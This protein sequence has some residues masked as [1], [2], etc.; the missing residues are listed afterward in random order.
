MLLHDEGGRRDVGEK[1]ALGKAELKDVAYVLPVVQY[2]S[3]IKIHVFPS[4][5]LA[6]FC[7]ERFFEMETPG[8]KD[9]A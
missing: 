6:V 3:E 7:G 9:Y 4:W 5:S 2:S 1:H 8:Q